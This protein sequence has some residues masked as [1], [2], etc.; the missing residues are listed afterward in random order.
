MSTST[1]NRCIHLYII[2][3]ELIVDCMQKIEKDRQ[4]CRDQVGIKGVR[5]AFWVFGN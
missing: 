4:G 2:N 5:M 3:G 1:Q